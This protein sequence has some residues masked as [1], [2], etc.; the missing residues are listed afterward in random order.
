[1]HD[2]AEQLELRE[3]CGDVAGAQTCAAD[4]L[5]DAGRRVDD[6]GVDGGDSRLDNS[7]G[8]G[9]SGSR[10]LDAEGLEHVGGRRGWCR[11]EA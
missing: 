9:L 3:R 11:T 6:G 10:T 2:Q 4:E 7:G 8:P 5:V 1:M